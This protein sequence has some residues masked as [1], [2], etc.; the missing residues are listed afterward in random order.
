MAISP[1]WELTLGKNRVIII[2]RLINKDVT[3]QV[4]NSL[5]S[6]WLLVLRSDGFYFCLCGSKKDGIIKVC[7]KG[8]LNTGQWKMLW[9]AER[10]ARFGHDFMTCP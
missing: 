7:A 2:W 6:V 10:E 3:V 5:I 9:S 8:D 4:N 1:N